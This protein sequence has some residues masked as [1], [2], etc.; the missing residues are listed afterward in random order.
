MAWLAAINVPL[1]GFG[2]HGL[3]SQGDNGSFFLEPMLTM[4]ISQ[5]QDHESVACALRSGLLKIELKEK[6]QKTTTKICLR[7]QSGM[8]LHV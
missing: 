2:K 1:G 8:E 6:Q 4:V 7:T 3:M 5:R